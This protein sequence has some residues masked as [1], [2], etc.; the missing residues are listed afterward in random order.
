MNRDLLQDKEDYELMINSLAGI[1]EDLMANAAPQEA[2]SYIN[3]ALKICLDDFRCR[4]SSII[5]DEPN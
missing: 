5:R 3:K 2:I 1:E 4:F